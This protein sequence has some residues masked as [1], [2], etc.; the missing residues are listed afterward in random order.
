MRPKLSI[1]IGAKSAR[2]TLGECLSVLERQRGGD[3]V[4]IIVVDGSADD[5]VKIA[6]KR[7]PKV[8]L[9]KSQESLLIP[10]LWEI[11]I[12]QSKGDIVA[13][14]AAHCIPR[15]NWIEQILKKHETPYAGIGGA[16]ENDPSS[17]LLD[18]SIYFTRYS[19]Y[20]LPFSEANVKDFAGDN[21]S[22][23]R[24]ALYSCNDARR[25]GFWEP[26]VHAELIDKGLE[27]L[28]TP[29]IVVYH[30]K[31]FT[32]SGFIKQRFLHG[33]QFGESRASCLSGAGRAMY[34]VL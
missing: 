20:M 24:S 4:E 3:Q 33:R 7:F 34:I 30:K 10:Q 14:I 32:M 1:I 31:S 18:W 25:N 19:S 12:S 8:M 15:E 16:V 5:T 26:F 11:G 22:Y 9:I 13:I 28:K 2:D 21:A 17:G 27:L 23:K 6:S 29:D